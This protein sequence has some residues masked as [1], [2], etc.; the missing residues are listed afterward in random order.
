M[1]E[2]AGTPTI[3]IFNRFRGKKA[4]A[5]NLTHQ[6]A[7]KRCNLYQPGPLIKSGKLGLNVNCVLN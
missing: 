5:R 3:S 4:E 7:V 6:E 2:K 1:P